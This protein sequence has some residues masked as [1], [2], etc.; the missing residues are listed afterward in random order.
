MRDYLDILCIAYLDDILIYSLD[1]RTYKDNVCCILK[2]LL[3][4]GL[5]DNLSKCVW[6]ILEIGF[7]SFVLTTEG[8]KMELNRIETIKD[9]PEPASVRDIQVFLAFANFYRRFIKGFSPIAAS[10]T[11]IL[12][13]G[14]KSK[15][16][17]HFALNPETRSAFETL[18]ETFISAPI[19]RHFDPLL[20]IRIET[21]ASGFALSGILS[22]FN[23]NT[24]H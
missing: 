16:K 24:G 21:D 9:W 10:L 7:L 19:L 3:K 4:H 15:F 2:C 6:S 12:Q 23:P 13:G 17:G 18:R 22:Q 11:G 5:F 14:Q 20:P 8:V 1:T